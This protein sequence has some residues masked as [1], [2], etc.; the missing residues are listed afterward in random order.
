M[1]FVDTRCTR[2][3]VSPHGNFESRQSLHGTESRCYPH[4]RVL[5]CS[6]S[7]RLSKDSV[8]FPVDSAFADFNTGMWDNE[9]QSFGIRINRRL[10]PRVA[11]S[12]DGE[13]GNRDFSDE[14]DDQDEIRA[15]LSINWEAGRRLTFA[16][17]VRYE[18][19]EGDSSFSNYEELIGSVSVYYRLLG[20]G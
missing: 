3:V 14:G 10:T 4:Q 5:D 1:T 16:L 11:F 7:T 19:R 9:N 13:F 8:W 18:D 2:G 12:L 17:G 6:D 20:A 15:N